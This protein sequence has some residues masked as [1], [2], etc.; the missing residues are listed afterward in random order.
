MKQ[1]PPGYTIEVWEDKQNGTDYWNAEVYFGGESVG[2]ARAIPNMLEPKEGDL[3]FAVDVY[4]GPDGGRYVFESREAA[5]QFVQEMKAT[6]NG[7]SEIQEQA[8]TS[9]V[10]DP[11]NLKAWDLMVGEAHRR[12]GLAT[13]MYQEIEKAS[14]K[15]ILPGDMQT[16][17]GKKFRESLDLNERGLFVA[18]SQ[19]NDILGKVWPPLSTSRF[20]NDS[21]EYSEKPL[22]IYSS[23]ARSR[24]KKLTLQEALSSEV[25]LLQTSEKNQNLKS[26][27]ENADLP[28]QTKKEFLNWIVSPTPFK[29]SGES[30]VAIV[31]NGQILNYEPEQDPIEGLV[32]YAEF[33]VEVKTST[34]STYR[35]IFN[36]YWVSSLP[37]HV[38]LEFE[39]FF[40]HSIEKY[41]ELTPIKSSAPSHGMGRMSAAS[42]PIDEFLNT[43]KEVAAE[44]GFAFPDKAY[45]QC[46]DFS[47][48]VVYMAQSMGLPIKLWSSKVTLRSDI[49]ELNQG[50]EIG[51]TLVKI[52]DTFYDFT[53][54]QFDPD[55]DFPHV[56]KKDPQYKELKQIQSPEALGDGSEFYYRKLWKK[57]DGVSTEASLENSTIT[58]Y[59]GSDFLP[60]GQIPSGDGD[61]G[62]YFTDSLDFAKEFALRIHEFHLDLSRI[63]DMRKPEH[64]KLVEEKFGPDVVAKLT[65]GPLG[66]PQ[67]THDEALSLIHTV[68]RDL[69]FCGAVE[70][71]NFNGH[72]SFEV[73][74]KSCVK[75]VRTFDWTEEDH[76][77][78]KKDPVLTA[79]KPY[80]PDLEDAFSVL[81][82]IADMD[83]DGNVPPEEEAIF[84]DKWD[85]AVSAGKTVSFP[86]E[87]VAE[88][89]EVFDHGRRV[90]E[91]HLKNPIIVA[92]VGDYYSVLDGSHR[93]ITAY[94]KKRKTIDAFVVSLPWANALFNGEGYFLKDLDLKVK[95]AISKKKEPVL[96]IKTKHGRY[97]L[98]NT[99]ADT[100]GIFCVWANFKNKEVGYSAFR[101]LD[102]ETIQPISDKDAIEFSLDAGTYVLEDFQRQGIATAMYLHAEKASGRKLIP[103]DDRTEDAKK[104]WA[105][106]NRP[107]G[108]YTTT[109][110]LD[111][112]S[113]GFL[114]E[115]LLMLD[116][117][118][119][120]V[121][122][123]RDKLLQIAM[124]KLKLKD[125]QYEEV[126]EP[127][128]LYLRHDGKPENDFHREHLEHIFE[129]CNES[130]LQPGEA[131]EKI[132]DW[133][134]ELKGKVTPCGDCVHT[135]LAFLYENGLLDRAD[136]GDGG[137]IPGTF[138]YETF[139]L[140]PLK[141][142]ARH[143]TGAKEDRKEL[144]GYDEE[145]IHDALVDCRNQLK[146]LNHYMKVLLPE[147]VAACVFSGLEKIIEEEITEIHFD[148]NWNGFR[149]VGGY[150]SYEGERCFRVLAIRDQDIVAGLRLSEHESHFTSENMWVLDSYRRQ[151]LM[152]KMMDLVEED[153]GLSVEPS[154]DRSMDAK[155]FWEKRK[156]ESKAEP[157][158]LK[159]WRFV[160]D[161]L[162]SQAD[163]Y[164]PGDGVLGQGTYLRPAEEA[165]PTTMDWADPDYEEDD[166]PENWM[167]VTEYNLTFNRLAE[168]NDENTQGLWDSEFTSKGKNPLFE[169]EIDGWDISDLAKKKGFDG[170]LVTGEDVD[171]GN[172]ILIPLGKKPKAQVL[173]H[174]LYFRD[175]NLAKKVA[176]KIKGRTKKI[177][178]GIV[179]EVLPAKAS[180]VDQILKES[181]TQ[182][183]VQDLD[184]CLEN[185]ES[186]LAVASK[187]ACDR[188][189]TRWKTEKSSKANLS[190]SANPSR[191]E[192]EKAW[193]ERF[194][195]SEK[196][197]SNY[198]SSDTPTLSGLTRSVANSKRFLIPEDQKLSAL[199]QLNGDTY[200][201]HTPIEAHQILAAKKKDWDLP[202][203]VLPTPL[204][205]F[206]L[207]DAKR[208]QVFQQEGKA[209]GCVTFQ[210]FQELL[211]KILLDLQ[212]T[213]DYRKSVAGILNQKRAQSGLDLL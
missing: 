9:L 213:E 121:I 181:K 92:K 6:G 183:A 89:F 51:H 79:V 102:Q 171:G 87:F 168:I 98:F 78:S 4:D 101:V 212:L 23:K 197:E 63:L 120:G 169:G 126:G 11:K 71:E 177:L 38:V 122:P 28:E 211:S 153:R 184:G 16:P 162:I 209:M 196:T 160:R 62:A 103:S 54:R 204:D 205:D 77:E 69:G 195:I 139:D 84:R 2:F 156:V 56:F 130:N 34:A 176:Y 81:L 119:T 185:S 82:M 166:N 189:R 132:C 188:M 45:W 94:E 33:K 149:L 150:G 91:E 36:G 22:K 48:A 123:S 50:E 21:S 134:G 3:E 40:D 148:E 131:K 133:L 113:S 37:N 39:R 96:K 17:D 75:P 192:N 57:I 199:S 14:G 191:Q 59:H 88:N 93:L 136:I 145:N 83:D 125:N 165:L 112:T 154:E 200:P 203:H 128:V 206:S 35:M 85:K 158:T 66:L 202:E 65:Q 116:C 100:N 104:L 68:I 201:E 19:K 186:L 170:V 107:F 129:R 127:L 147:V 143:R 179:V 174:H 15:K 95:A 106:P 198:S 114:P 20:W 55:L 117:E 32:R 99:L 194:E 80:Q 60:E 44:S 73:Y 42:N 24:R 70:D 64:Q 208:A 163:P 52:K 97:N 10:K 58:V 67:A 193:L 141:A 210:D 5:D 74:D 180:L 1:L 108:K 30:K 43:V 118:M 167:I 26:L 152:S 172:Q 138:H 178:G 110:T 115:D 111:E 31:P 155:R 25:S 7:C 86:M 207:D 137:P 157:R 182:A 41:E 142:M 135:D 173:K 47:N 49:G 72:I 8:I 29:V 190:T 140:N 18:S 164:Y 151:G 109:A 46:S 146:E 53:A 13:L 175:S 161:I 124:L 105:Q 12:K 61:A 144:A 90:E 159:A 187:D 76:V 27:I